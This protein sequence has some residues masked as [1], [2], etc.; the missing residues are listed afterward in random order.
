MVLDDRDR[1]GW[2]PPREFETFRGGMQEIR[3]IIGRLDAVLDR[4]EEQEREKE[5]R[6][7]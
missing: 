2:S 3:S 4:L 7:G 6:N 5:S 1:D